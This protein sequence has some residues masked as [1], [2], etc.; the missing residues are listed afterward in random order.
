MQ[1]R[2][3]RFVGAVV[4]FTSVGVSAAG[5][6]GGTP[7]PPLQPGPCATI[8]PQNPD[9]MTKQFLTLNLKAQITSCSQ[10]NQ[11]NLV[12]AFKGGDLFNGATDAY[13]FTCNAPESL[14]STQPLSYTLSPGASMGV[15]CSLQTSVNDT[16][17]SS[18]TASGTGTATLYA[19]CQ[20]SATA[21][22]SASD[23][24]LPCT[25]VLGTGIYPWS[26]NVPIPPPGPGVRPPH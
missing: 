4:L 26:V 16:G 14:T 19:D 23:Q 6:S 25:T 20:T 12:V 24:S 13:V 5:A 9:P 3:W 22:Q 8:V 11:S 15:G 18:Y 10:L 21:L 7:P 2:L 1:V 17:S